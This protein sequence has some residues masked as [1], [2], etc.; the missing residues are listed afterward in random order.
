[1]RLFSVEKEEM[2][3]SITSWYWPWWKALWMFKS[4]G[5]EQ[6]QSRSLRRNGYEFCLPPSPENGSIVI[7]VVK[8]VLDRGIFECLSNL[9]SSSHGPSDLIRCPWQLTE[10]VGHPRNIL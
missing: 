9:L 7:R 1:M 6:R 2:S 10:I 3:K 5:G 4:S 8:I